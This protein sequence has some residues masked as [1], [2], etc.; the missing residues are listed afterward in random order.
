MPELDILPDTRARVARQVIRR[1]DSWGNV[2]NAV[3]VFCANCGH[4]AGDVP[5]DNCTFAF[6]LCGEEANNCAARWGG[7][8]HFYTEPDTI[9]WERVKNEQMERHERLLSP[10][11]LLAALDDPSNPITK[12][13]KERMAK[14][15]L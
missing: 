6:F 8:A 3:P 1:T 5:E 9:F 14:G 2:Y 10:V 12:L 13:L 11:E 4:S 7:Q 15:P